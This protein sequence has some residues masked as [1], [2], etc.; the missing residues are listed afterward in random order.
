MIDLALFS[1]IALALVAGPLG[2]FV[3][4][5]RMAYF[6][7]AL[8]HS[9]LLGVALGVAISLQTE[10]AILLVGLAF[11]A[12]LF[13]LQRRRLLANDTLLG[14]LAHATLAIGLL[15]MALMGEHTH[16]VHEFLVGSLD[17][18]TPTQAIYIIAGAACALAILVRFWSGLVL[19]TVNEDLAQAEG[20][21]VKL[22]EAILMIVMALVVSVAIQ[23]VGILLITSLLI[24]PAAC[25]RLLAR[26]PEHMAVGAAIMGSACVSL[27]YLIAQQTHI[28]PGPVIVSA[29]VSLFM[30]LVLIRSLT[31]PHS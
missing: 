1:G 27:G 12:L 25:A 23:L 4:W 14:I 10:L 15:A 18:V 29:L 31:R 21:G 20:V 2:C 7:D 22:H 11:V 8:S 16:D 6:G 26:T 9:A 5:R 19:M 28:A 30:L 13:L 17:A 3:V 24:I